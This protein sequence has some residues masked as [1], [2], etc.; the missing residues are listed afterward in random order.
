MADGLLAAILAV[1]GLGVLWIG[2][3]SVEG[4]TDPNLL[5]TLLVIGAS[6]PIALRRQHPIPVL[7][8]V[9]V[10]QFVLEILDFHTGGWMSIFVALYTVAAHTSGRP[11][12]ITAKLFGLATLPLL[13]A[14]VMFSNLRIGELVSSI[15]FLI[16]SFMLGDYLKRRRR[17][18]AEAAERDSIA[19]RERELLARQQVQDERARI[20]RELHDVVAHSVSLMIIQSGAARRSIVSSPVQAEQALRELEATGRQAMDE[21]R[22]VL[23]VLRTGET[24]GTELTPQ[25]TLA[26][27]RSLVSDDPTL[28]VVLTEVGTPHGDVPSSIG[29][30]LYRVVQE[31]LTNVRKHA[32]PVKHVEVTVTYEPRR[33]VVQVTDDGRGASVTPTAGG[34]GLAGMRERMALCGGTVSAGPRQGGGWHVRASAPINEQS[35]K[36]SAVS[37]VGVS[38]LD[39]AT[40]AQVGS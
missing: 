39:S 20:A 23:G 40:P 8:V 7:A 31:A 6:A 38:R 28:N 4:A 18:A 26:D 19:A 37:D 17:Q 5:S 33:I 24:D 22:R 10:N 29:L 16:G 3:S 36:A 15:V 21:L 14:G 9:T 27:I 34:H 35:S 30:S 1:S 32:G 13:I 11:L 12:A 25:P 2:S